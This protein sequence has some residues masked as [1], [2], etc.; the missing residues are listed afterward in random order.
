[1]RLITPLILPDR[2]APVIADADMAGATAPEPARCVGDVE[3]TG[4]GP[5]PIGEGGVTRDGKTR[6]AG[7]SPGV[8]G[9]EEEG[10]GPSTTHMRCERVATSLA[11]VWASVL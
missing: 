8:G 10:E 7:V 4:V 6:D 2:L 3:F 5:D 1:V 9:P 11:T